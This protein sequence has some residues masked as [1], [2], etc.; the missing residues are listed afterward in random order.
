MLRLS[1]LMLWTIYW[2]FSLFND[3]FKNSCDQLAI[4]IPVSVSGW[5]QGV[6]NTEVE[7]RAATS[8]S[9]VLRLG[10]VGTEMCDF[11]GSIPCCHP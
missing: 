5:Q 7:D 10:S 2:E 9:G 6:K 3:V 8:R 1:N 4:E 11:I